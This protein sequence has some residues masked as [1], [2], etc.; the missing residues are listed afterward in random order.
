MYAVFFSG[1]KYFTCF[2]D[3]EVNLHDLVPFHCTCHFTLFLT[4]RFHCV[5]CELLVRCRSDLD[6]VVVTLSLLQ[7]SS[8]HTDFLCVCPQRH[9]PGLAVSH[10]LLMPW[11]VVQVCL[12]TLLLVCVSSSKLISVFKCQAALRYSLINW[13]DGLHMFFAG[14]QRQRV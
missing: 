13:T 3:L 7:R 9:S 2:L 10:E 6:W 11:V 12:H 1:M 5:S 4:C 8:S 14:R